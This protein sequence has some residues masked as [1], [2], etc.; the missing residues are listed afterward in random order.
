MH[1]LISLE[2][3]TGRKLTF[4]VEFDYDRGEKAVHYPNDVAH[5]GSPPCVEPTKA[6]L[7]NPTWPDEDAKAAVR[8][9]WERYDR[10]P[11]AIDEQ[12]F[13]SLEE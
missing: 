13:E 4:E 11:E 1:T 8:W 9:F 7:L 12:L 3:G 10:N 2:T 5:P 6:T